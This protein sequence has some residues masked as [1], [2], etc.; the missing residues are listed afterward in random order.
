MFWHIGNNIY[1]SQKHCKTQVIFLNSQL[2]VN[3]NRNLI[4]T[5]QSRK[6]TKLCV[7]Q[8][9][10]SSC[11]ISCLLSST[12]LKYTDSTF[13][14]FSLT[15]HCMILVGDLLGFSAELRITFGDR[16]TF[17]QVKRPV[18]FENILL[19]GRFA[20]QNLDVAS[21]ASCIFLFSIQW[22]RPGK[23]REEKEIAV[24]VYTHWKIVWWRWFRRGPVAIGLPLKQHPL[25]PKTSIVRRYYCTRRRRIVIHCAILKANTVSRRLVARHL[26]GVKLPPFSIIRIIWYI[27][28]PGAYEGS[29]AFS[30]SR[31]GSKI[32]SAVLSCFCVGIT[33]RKRCDCQLFEPHF[34]KTA[35]LSRGK[36]DE[37]QIVKHY[38][39]LLIIISVN[40]YRQVKV[41]YQD[42]AAI[43]SY[44][45]NVAST[46]E[47]T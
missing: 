19:L 33:A 30:E 44:R 43:T 46:V 10:L 17:R 2:Y 27:S 45:I 20:F 5:S 13:L 26:V 36:Y 1:I 7:T 37:N 28:R 6:C 29:A 42:I 9:T 40:S 3:E 15:T 8:F 14:S 21:T 31:L 4:R 25:S 12:F 38:E 16:Y 35:R 41:L 18:L 23:R 22:I 34:A 24:A 11:Q 39:L 47:I 32:Y